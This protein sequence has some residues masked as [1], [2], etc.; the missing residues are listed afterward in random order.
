MDLKV[1]IKGERCCGTNYLYELIK[2]NIDVHLCNDL[3][4]KH[5]FINAFVNQNIFYVNNYL[6]IFIFRDPIDWINSLYKTKWCLEK[7]TYTNISEF[8]RTQPKQ[9]VQDIG[10]L[11]KL[12]PKTE[13]YWER[14]PLTLRLA[15]N[16]CQLRNWKNLNF[17]SATNVFPNVEYIKYEELSKNPEKFIS[18]LNQKYFNQNINF[19]N[20]IWYKGCKQHGEYKKKEYPAIT[21]DDFI[22]IK[23]E[24]DLEIENKIGY[25]LTTI[26]C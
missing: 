13:L 5:S 4:W 2:S 14:H 6:L 16:I 26:N 20:V 3:G 21:N 11:E 10:H 9:R 23:K 24:L 25:K 12:D 18:D 19:K 17:L 22:F 7:N 15:D 8:M 1:I